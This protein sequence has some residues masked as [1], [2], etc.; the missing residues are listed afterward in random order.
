[1]LDYSVPNIAKLSK[2]LQANQLDFNTLV[3]AVLKTLDDA[4]T[5]AANWIFEILDDAITPAA[6]WIFEISKILSK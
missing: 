5:P 6:N 2:N 3:E 4:I 1:M